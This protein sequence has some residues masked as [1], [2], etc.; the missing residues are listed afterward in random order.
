M[1]AHGRVWPKGER[2]ADFREPL[3]GDVPVRAISGEFAPVTPPRYGDA[4][5]DHL[6]N[7]RHLVLP[8]QGHS[9]LGIGCMPKLYAQFVESAD[10]TA[11]DADC[12]QRLKTT[13]PFAGT[14]G[15][16]P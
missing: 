12:L 13:P 1:L 6:S 16:G 9:V 7:G 8:G 11:L 15:W 2:A 3:A 5:V 14:Y 10:A 4:V